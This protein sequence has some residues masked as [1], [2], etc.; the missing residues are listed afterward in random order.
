MAHITIRKIVVEE[1]VPINKPI[2]PLIMAVLYFLLFYISD[3][4]IGMCQ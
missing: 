4:I 1:Y 3:L 2:H